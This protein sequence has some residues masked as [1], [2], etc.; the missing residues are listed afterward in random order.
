[1]AN[2]KGRG[3]QPT[4]P[5]LTI[6]EV[7]MGDIPLV[8]GERVTEAAIADIHDVYREIIR[9]QN[10]L[11]PKSKRLRGMTNASFYTLFRLARYLGLV[12][13]VRDEP[14]LYPPPHGH[15][16]SMRKVAGSE[17]PRAA[18]STRRIYKLTEH[19][20]NAEESWRNL[21][22]AWRYHRANLESPNP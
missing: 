1:M 20:R 17:R 15:L 10:Q 2:R 3:S 13:F 19:G 4:H 5:G 6:K 16:Y 9:Q 22:R 11:R 7:L 14:M 8:N 21:H 12:E 18:V